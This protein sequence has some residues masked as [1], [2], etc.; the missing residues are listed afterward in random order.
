MKK[1]T[2][3]LFCAGLGLT[4]FAGCMVIKSPAAQRVS[5]I[6]CITV[7]VEPQN[8]EGILD[9]PLI[10]RHL[11]FDFISEDQMPSHEIHQELKQKIHEKYQEQHA[12]LF[13]AYQAELEEANAI[14]LG[15]QYTELQSQIKTLSE[16][17]KGLSNDFYNSNEYTSLKA[18]LDA[19]MAELVNLEK[20]NDEYNAVKEQLDAVWG[21]ISVLAE[22]LNSQKMIIRFQKNEAQ[23][24]LMQ[25]INEKKS[26]LDE[27]FEVITKKF[28]DD[29]KVIQLNL[30]T[31]LKVLRKTLFA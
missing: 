2:R 21:K 6:P 1:I 14:I 19:L 3:I 16:E 9:N 7:C 8:F 29:V 20:G 25:L 5:A 23:S 26:A 28:L 10:P 13:R 4:F 30:R 17:Y 31:E 15:S 24:S 27:Q 22:E 12:E 18:E 11:P